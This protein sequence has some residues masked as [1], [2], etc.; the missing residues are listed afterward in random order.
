MNKNFRRQVE[1][2]FTQIIALRPTTP[3]DIV[4]AAR[5]LSRLH[6]AAASSEIQA[7]RL[8][9]RFCDA[10]IGLSAELRVARLGSAIHGVD[11]V[12]LAGDQLDA[13]GVDLIFWL[14][15][16]VPLHVQVKAGPRPRRV[17]STH[18]VRVIIAQPQMHDADLLKEIHA[19]IWPSA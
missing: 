10:V 5:R 14:A 15:E 2:P 9:S 19:A 1:I 11:S 17:E 8:D 4:I 7:M 3:R 16:N 13:R 6:G 18:G 12:I